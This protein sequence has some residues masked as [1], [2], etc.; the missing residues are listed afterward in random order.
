M[1]TIRG[2]M[3]KE[4]DQRIKAMEELIG[5]MRVIKMYCWE[6]FSLKKII[7]FRTSEINIL[8]LRGKVFGLMQAILYFAP[9]LVTTMTFFAYLMLSTVGQFRASD[10][11]TTFSFCGIMGFYLRM[12]QG[13]IMDMH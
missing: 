3:A 5:A 8:K 13:N 7:N 6:S 12:F 11:F 10:V 2:Q 9:H 4:S 1:G